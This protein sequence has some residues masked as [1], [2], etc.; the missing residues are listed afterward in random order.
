MPFLSGFPRIMEDMQ[1]FLNPAVADLDG[2]G[3]PEAIN[4]SAGHILHAFDHR[5]REPEGWPKDTG[6]W[7]LGSPAVGDA[8][9][10]GFLEVWTATRDGHLFAW[11]TTAEAAKAYRSWTGFHHDPRN[12]GNCHTELR[13]YPPLPEETGCGGCSDCESSVSAGGGAWGRGRGSSLVVFALLALAGGRLR[14]APG[15]SR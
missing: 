15:R 1:F 4:G 6:Q 5:G 2:D 12:T 3:L 8:D 14:R 9:G 13:T 11:R 7:I 10:D